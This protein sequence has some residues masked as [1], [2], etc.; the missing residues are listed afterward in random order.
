MEL[1]QKEGGIQRAESLLRIQ[2]LYWLLEELDP[3]GD[4]ERVRN[5]LSP[6]HHPRGNIDKRHFSSHTLPWEEA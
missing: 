6:I 1:I 4:P 5:A 2:L 3:V